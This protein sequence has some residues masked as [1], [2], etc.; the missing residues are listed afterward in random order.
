MLPSLTG[1]LSC[2]EAGLPAA[3]T[4]YLNSNHKEQLHHVDQPSM[5]TSWI[6]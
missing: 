4:H 1:E 2:D 3:S 6:F 5:E